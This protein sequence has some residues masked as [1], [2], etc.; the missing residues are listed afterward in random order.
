M[1]AQ[2]GRSFILKLGTA[3]AGTK[4]AAMRETSF[5]INGEAVESTNKD[6]SG[7]RELVD[8]AGTT[9]MT[10]SASGVLTGVAQA[11]TLRGYA[12]DKSL[13]AYGIVWDDGDT[14]DA[15][16]QLTVFEAA[17]SHNGEQ[18]YSI[19]LESSGSVTAA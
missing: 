13:N 11:Q 5:T 17:G 6:S 12:A 10:I 2:K 4:I 3:A 16:F 14:L 15:S 8:G 7:W 18:T 1:A 19:T 9:S